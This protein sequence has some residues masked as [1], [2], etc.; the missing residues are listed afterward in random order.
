MVDHTELLVG[1]AQ[2]IG[3]IKGQVD[4]LAANCDRCA[5]LQNERY[6]TLTRRIA[7]RAKWRIAGWLGGAGL[8][9]GGVWKAIFGG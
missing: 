2:D 5:A 4:F 7:R 1:M 3:H 6:A 8:F 9:I